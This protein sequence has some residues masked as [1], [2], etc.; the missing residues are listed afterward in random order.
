MPTGLIHLTMSMGTGRAEVTEEEFDEILAD[1]IGM[2]VDELRDLSDSVPIG[3]PW[4][5]EVVSDEQ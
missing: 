2:D 1:E 4:D 3:D 5:A